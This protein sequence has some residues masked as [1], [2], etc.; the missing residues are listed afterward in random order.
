M[1]RNA[2]R[3]LCL[4]LVFAALSVGEA[5]AAAPVATKAVDTEVERLAAGAGGVVGIAAWRL[6]G[7]GS[8]VLFNAD[9]SFPM[10]STYKVPLA[11]KIFDMVDKGQI[12]LDTMLDVPQEMMS[13]SEVIAD[14]F[15]HSGVSLSVHN[16]LEVMLTQSDNTATDVLMKA[17]GGPQAVTAWA[18]AQGVTAMRVDRDT[19]RLLRD[20]YGLGEGPLTEAFDKAAKAEPSLLTKGSKPDATFDADPRDTASPA[21]MATLLT[22]MFA[23]KALSPE[24]TKAFTAI[25][26]RCRTGA[27]RLPGQMPPGTIVAHKTGT[28]GGTVNDVG[29]VSLPDGTGVVIAAYVK[30]SAAPTADRERAIAEIARTIRDY[31]LF[32]N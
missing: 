13:P 5:S 10:A 2:M 27:A 26:E 8:R 21:A 1:K 14:R 3:W 24:S 29:M 17:A 18:R 22:R 16:L 12:R 31:F 7:K 30:T 32:A 9:A 11:G 4:P 25:M 15:I 23:G 20:F 28:I 6:D 19:N